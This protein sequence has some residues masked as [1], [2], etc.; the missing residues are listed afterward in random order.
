MTFDEF[1]FVALNYSKENPEQR[2]GQAFLNALK[3]KE[4]ANRKDIYDLYYHD[5]VWSGEED[6]RDAALKDAYFVEMLEFIERHW[7]ENI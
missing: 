2:Q 5:I 1:Y 7:D 6:I 3:L 4:Y